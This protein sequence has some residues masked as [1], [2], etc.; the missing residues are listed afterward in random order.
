M[1][2]SSNVMPVISKIYCSSSPTMLTVRK[3]PHVVNGG[4]FV[5]LNSSQNL[6]FTVEGCG[7]LGAKGE[8]V[9]K[10]GDGGSILSIT[11]KGGIAQALR[12]RN[13]WNGYLMDYEGGKKFIFSLT[14]PK[15]PMSNAIRIHLEHKGQ[16][17]GW[18]FEVNGSFI[19]RACTIENYKGNIIAQVEESTGGKDLYHVMVQPGHDQA[20]TVGVV[21]I[22]DN[23]YGE[24]TRC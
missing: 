11:K 23:I 12:T 20:F 14:D 15:C 4:G 2:G 16:S 13:R 22:L 19:D 10:D 1:G 17:K 24:S 9:L 6:V 5:V 7:T 21:A 18:D 3:R 8:L